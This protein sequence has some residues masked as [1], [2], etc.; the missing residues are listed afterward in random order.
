MARRT[1]RKDADVGT[2]PK[3]DESEWEDWRQLREEMGRRLGGR[4]ATGVSDPEVL[5]AAR[6]A[7]DAQRRR[8]R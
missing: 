5:D 6:R 3:V 8:K 4:G 2:D 1:K 7:T